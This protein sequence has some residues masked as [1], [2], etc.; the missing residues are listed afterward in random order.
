[1]SVSEHAHTSVGGGILSEMGI[2]RSLQD[3]EPPALVNIAVTLYTDNSGSGVPTRALLAPGGLLRHPLEYCE[4]HALDRSLAWAYDLVHAVK[5]FLTYAL[6][7]QGADWVRLLTG[8]A[9]RLHKGTFDTNGSDPSGLYW[10]PRT[11]RD[12]REQ[13]SYLQGLFA[14]MEKRYPGIGFSSYRSAISPFDRKLEEAAYQHR[15][16]AALLGHTWPASATSMT[17]RQGTVIGRRRSPSSKPER[18]PEFPGDRFDE[19]LFDGFRVHGRPN[20]RDMLITL[21]LDKAAMRISEPFHL[22][23][24]DVTEDSL[25]PGSA[26]V[27]IHHPSLGLAPGRAHSP[28]GRETREAYLQ[29]EW[30]LVPRTDRSDAKHAGWKGGRHELVQGSLVFRAYWFPERY[31][32]LFFE[33]WHK[34]LAETFD[35]GRTHPFAFINTLRS[36]RGEMYSI[37]KYVEAH[38]AAVRRIGLVPEKYLGTTPHG[39]RHSYG[40]RAELAGVGLTYRMQAMHHASEKSQAVYTEPGYERVIAELR[41]AEAHRA[42]ALK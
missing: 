6:A 12:A 31:G 11:L 18:P 40:R 26:S 35:I 42:A 3:A 37:G 39:H 5:L 4:D 20:Y 36:P 7:N 21:L 29:R 27:L 22:Y 23:V 14:W 10:T 9:Q 1:M 32:Q 2:N 34:Y 41:A 8:F 17:S 30:G 25:N 15:R 24:S 38:A 16:N 19:L 33:L 28:N 13:L